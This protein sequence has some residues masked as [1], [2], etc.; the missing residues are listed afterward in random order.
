VKLRFFRFPFPIF[1]AHSSF[2]SFAMSPSATE[3]AT[4]TVPKFEIPKTCKAG[5]VVNEGPDFYVE[6]QDVEVP[7]PGPEEVLIKLNATGL[8]LSDIHMST[9]SR[10]PSP[11]VSHSYGEHKWMEKARELAS[12][13]SLT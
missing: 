8:C 5:V 13:K 4:E 3:T 6:V 7:I 12:G 1:Y 9:L 11:S 2:G 10:L